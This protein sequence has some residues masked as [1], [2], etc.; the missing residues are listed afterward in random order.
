MPSIFDLMPA[1]LW[2]VQPFRLPQD[3]ARSSAWPSVASGW[4]PAVPAPPPGW[5]TASADSPAEADASVSAWDRAMRQALAAQSSATGDRGLGALTSD[6]ILANA[7]RAHDFVTWVLGPPSASQALP[8]GDALMRGASHDV[9]AAPADG[10]AANANAPLPYISAPGEE[11]NPPSLAPADTDQQPDVSAAI[12]SPNI[13][14]QGVRAR[15]IAA[16][17]PP[18]PPAIADIGPEIY[19][20]GADAI[21]SINAGL[22]PF[23]AEA[24][25]GIAAEVKTATPTDALARYW[26]N[27]KRVGR[28]LLGI[29][30]LA[31]APLTGISRSL[32]G[33]ALQW[34]DANVMRKLAV[35]MFGEDKVRQIEQARGSP[36]G[37]SYE[38]AK[39]AVDQIM[40]GLGPRGGMPRA[41]LA[42]TTRAL[43]PP[44]IGPRS[45]EIAE[46][47]YVDPATVP[48]VPADPPD[49]DSALAAAR[50]RGIDPDALS[51]RAKEIHSV[52][53]PRAQTARTTAVLSTDGPTIIGGGKVDLEKG[54]LRLL[55]DGEIHS[56]LP[57][58]DA[59]PTVLTKAMVLRH[60]PLALA[61][62]R[63]ICS[64]CENFIKSMGGVISPSRTIAIFPGSF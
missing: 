52:L 47:P 4:T 46:P 6:Q 16:M 53:H 14:R 30:Q 48:L 18:P 21:H 55:R 26:E 11:A 58:A 19:R 64:S 3:P 12:G 27:E 57:R 63:P 51:A 8:L 45:V 40:M 24:L 2:P 5:P 50:R 42:P 56:E 9:G 44:P 32:G 17:R 35:K 60:R 23:S 37:L 22:N 20:A 10:V 25:A 31:A 59:E 34:F 1:S 13:E 15:A 41:R 39:H 36:G 43:P 54:Q 49:F 62:S 61:T 7:K 38:D 29:P 33:H 28:G